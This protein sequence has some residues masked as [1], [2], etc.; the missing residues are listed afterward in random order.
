[1]ETHVDQG[2]AIIRR[3]KW[4]Q[5]AL[6]V[7]SFHH[8][9]MEGK[10]YPRGLVGQEIPITA[11]IF[12]IADVFDALTSK[13]PYKDPWSFNKAME[14]LFEVK[15]THFDPELLDAFSRIAEPLYRKFGGKDE[16]PRDELKD[17][18]KRYFTEEMDSLDY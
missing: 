11:R 6:E 3:S 16:V 12:A 7:V 4:L 14:L 18:I 2:Q 5:D 17:I 8:E 15:G 1:M 13:R 10:G 9:K